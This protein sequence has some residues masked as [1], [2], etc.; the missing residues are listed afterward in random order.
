MKNLSQQIR[1]D[2]A[3]AGLGTVMSFYRVNERDPVES[4]HAIVPH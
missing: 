3:V 4:V 1:S 2:S